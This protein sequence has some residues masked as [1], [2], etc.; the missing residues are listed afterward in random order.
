[1]IQNIILSILVKL[2]MNNSFTQT[3]LLEI[4]Y[5][6][7]AI[8]GD[9]SKL[10]ILGFI[11]LKLGNFIPFLYAMITTIP[12][13]IIIG[14]LHLKTYWNCLFFS[15]IY[16]GLL[17]VSS[18]WI[19]YQYILY[20]LP[21]PSLVILMLAPQ[22]PLSSDRTLKIPKVTTKALAFI[23]I[24]IFSILFIIKKDPIY[25]IGPLSIIFQSIQ[26]ILI[27]GVKSHEKHKTKKLVL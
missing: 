20:A 21:L 13:R 2:N 23:L 3:E 9:L 19:T 7:L 15:L 25:Y 16:F 6:I 24:M 14:G 5:S 18:E 12:L 17:I 27:K 10:V 11:F 4:R 22:I 1:M 8:G 26:L